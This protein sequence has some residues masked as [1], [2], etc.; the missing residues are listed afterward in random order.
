M[1]ALDL[2]AQA[3]GPLAVSSSGIAIAA[4]TSTRLRSGSSGSSIANGLQKSLSGVTSGTIPRAAAS[5]TIVAWESMS[6]VW[7]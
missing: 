2:G 3:G 6:E 4:W 5:R 1:L 7:M